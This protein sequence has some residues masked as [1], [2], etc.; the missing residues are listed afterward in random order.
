M[1]ELVEKTGLPRTTIHHYLREGLLPPARK[2]A[3]NAAVYDETHVER[4]GLIRDLRGDELGP[5]GVQDIR[6]IVSMV[7]EGVEPGVA[8]RLRSASGRRWE[9]TEGIRAVGLSPSD[10]ARE[11]ELS[12]NTVRELI[13]VGLL[14][15]RPGGGPG[16]DRFDVADVEL[17]VVYRDLLETTSLEAS[18]LAPVAELM[19]EVV[20]YESA[21]ASVATANRS[22]DEVASLHRKMERS[23]ETIHT[24]LLSRSAR[25]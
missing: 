24:Y 8:A 5:F 9:T 7:E 14:L 12:L 21:L 2:T 23:L 19:G 13:E 25:A 4:L 18:D 15:G 11:S 6:A 22:E 10:L 3:T 17:A 20:R 16:V 1:R